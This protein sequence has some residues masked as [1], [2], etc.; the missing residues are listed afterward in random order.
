LPLVNERSG[1]RGGAPCCLP[2]VLALLPAD[3][4]AELL[5]YLSDPTTFRTITA[6]EITSALA[7]RNITYTRG[8]ITRHRRGECVTCRLSKLLSPPPSKV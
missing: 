6:G 5:R 8:A 1:P 3:E 7:A 4:S 2:E